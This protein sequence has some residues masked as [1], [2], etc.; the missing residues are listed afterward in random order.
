MREAVGRPLHSLP[1]SFAHRES[2]LV[3][4]P[5]LVVPANPSLDSKELPL[6]FGEEK[7]G[8]GTRR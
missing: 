1:L 3:V 6:A 7:F 8:A 2:C 5:S 4:R